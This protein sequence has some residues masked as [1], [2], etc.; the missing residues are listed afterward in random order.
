M[1][2]LEGLPTLDGYDFPNCQ[3]LRIR[4]DWGALPRR[5][6]FRECGKICWIS[7]PVL[8]IIPRPQTAAIVPWPESQWAAA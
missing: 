6:L 2:E 5:R 7:A 4:L 1:V 8:P 3:P